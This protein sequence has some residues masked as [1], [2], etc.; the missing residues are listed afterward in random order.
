V[1]AEARGPL[2]LREHL[3]RRAPRRAATEDALL[4]DPARA[5]V[6]SV[7]AGFVRLGV[8]EGGR[9]DVLRLDD[10]V[11]AFESRWVEG[12]PPRCVQEDV[13]PGVVAVLATRA[14]A[15]A[16]AAGRERP[17]GPA[18][19]TT[20]GARPDPGADPAAKPPDAPKPLV[21]LDAGFEIPVPGTSW[22]R[23]TPPPPGD[24]AGRRV[25]AKLWSALHAAE[26]RVEWEPKATG[27]AAEAEAALFAR[28]RALSPDLERAQAREAVPSLPGAWRSSLVGTLNGERVRTLVLVADRG[29]G[30]ATILATS[31][32]SAWPKAKPAL[33]A[34]VSGFRWL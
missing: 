13:A 29:T 24:P 5:D 32:E 12:D 11:R 18:G 26:V 7:R 8:G 21:V 6:R 4:V 34:V 14:Q 16:A 22:S 17:A 3:A 23:E 1:P 31:P 9:E 10:G 27:T 33:E 19:G 2:G 30:R 25:V 15:A 20:P 28:L